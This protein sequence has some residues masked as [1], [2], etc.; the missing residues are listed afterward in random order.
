MKIY[1]DP[2]L[3]DL[4]VEWYS[5]DCRDGT[6]EVVLSLTGID[7]A[8]FQ[9]ERVVPC[10]DLKATFADLPRERFRLDGALRMSGDP[11]FGTYT[12]ELDLRNGLDKRAY[13]YF[14][15]FENVRVELAFDMGAT[16]QSLMVDTIVVEFTSTSFP[17]PLAQPTLCGQDL[18]FTSLPDGIYTARARAVAGETTVAISPESAQAA[19]NFETFTD[20]GT[21]VMSPCDPS[22]P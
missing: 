10:T 8:T 19:V 7:D 14:G 13:L 17:E 16:C 11:L 22:C 20:F 12:E 5:F 4:D 18:L 9:A 15:G 21:L 3:P 1:P 2:E 6:P